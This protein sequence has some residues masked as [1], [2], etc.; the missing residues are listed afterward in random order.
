MFKLDTEQRG[1]EKEVV[2][3]VEPKLAIPT[4]LLPR[5]LRLGEQRHLLLLDLACYYAEGPPREPA[6]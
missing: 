5:S 1:Q 2:H 3:T 6:V 4:A